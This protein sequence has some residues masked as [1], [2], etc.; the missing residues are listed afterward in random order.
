M[1]RS[2][3]AYDDMRVIPAYFAYVP[4]RS[5][6]HLDI[7]FLLIFQQVEPISKTYHHLFLF[8]RRHRVMSQRCHVSKHTALMHDQLCCMWAFLFLGL[9]VTLSLP[10]TALAQDQSAVG[11]FFVGMA[12]PVA[13]SRATLLL[14]SDLQ[15]PHTFQWQSSDVILGTIDTG[16]VTATRWTLI[17]GAPDRLVFVGSGNGTVVTGNVLFG[18]ANRAVVDIVKGAKRVR[19]LLSG[20]EVAVA[21]VDEHLHQPE[22]VPIPPAEVNAPFD[23]TPG[24][25]G[26]PGGFGGPP[27]GSGIPALADPFRIEHLQVSDTGDLTSAMLTLTL[28]SNVSSF[29][30]AYTLTETA[31]DSNL[32]VDADDAL[33]IQVIRY[34]AH[35]PGVIDTMHLFVVSMAFGARRTMAVYETGTD[36]EVFASEHL[37]LA[38]TMAQLPHPNESDMMTATLVSN[39]RSGVVSDTLAETGNDTLVF[40]SSDHAFRMTVDRITAKGA[41]AQD[42]L[43]AFVTSTQFGVSDV[44]INAIET[45]P[46]TLAFRTDALHNAGGPGMGPGAFN[47]LA[48][49]NKWAP[50]LLLKNDE[51]WPFV[52]DV[53]E[54]EVR[55]KRGEATSNPVQNPTLKWSKNVF[56]SVAEFRY[57]VL[58]QG[59]DTP[60]YF[61]LVEDHTGAQ[62]P[63]AL[64]GGNIDARVRPGDKLIASPKGMARP[65]DEILVVQ[66]D[67][68]QVPQFLFASAKYA[69]PLKFEIKGVETAFIHHITGT[70]KIGDDGPHFI[71]IGNRFVA[72]DGPEQNNGTSTV[73]T[74][75]VRASTYLP[76]HSMVPNLRTPDAR[77]TLQVTFSRTASDLLLFAQAESDR[78]DPEARPQVFVDPSILAL[79]IGPATQPNVVTVDM[80]EATQRA[81]HKPGKKSYQHWQHVSNIFP[82]NQ[83]VPHEDTSARLLSF[84]FDIDD[85]IITQTATQ[86]T[87]FTRLEDDVDVGAG[88]GREGYKNRIYGWRRGGYFYVSYGG[89]DISVLDPNERAMDLT[90]QS[91]NFDLNMFPTGMGRITNVLQQNGGFNTANAVP[92]AFAI[93]SA[94]AQG[95]PWALVF[96]TAEGIFDIIA[97]I[98]NN[99]IT[100]TADGSIY[101]V[102]TRSRANGER[103]TEG[104]FFPPFNHTANGSLG[105]L[106]L[107]LSFPGVST[108]VGDQWAAFVELESACSAVSRIPQPFLSIDVSNRVEFKVDNVDDFN[109]F[110]VIISE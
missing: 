88:S 89:K 3:S 107:P 59:E 72:N 34:A 86:I 77:F 24:E 93:A 25:P 52:Q 12:P 71:G 50:F 9:L 68:L 7:F 99:N 79:D 13:N 43:T 22:L 63:F 101:R 85:Q 33:A 69:T 66:V 30:Q 96:G 16:S 45:G 109:K 29:S 28:T 57:H 21:W 51:P 46:N 78:Q 4:Q 5:T 61:L 74:A 92:G 64:N 65:K 84:A 103:I 100:D 8:H 62:A 15:A 56:T 26:G 10:S 108:N 39:V 47:G 73:Y 110:K 27:A 6:R 42:D 102:L 49:G 55:R 83:G 91:G 58:V 94:I 98:D 70:I 82:H 31:P 40:E 53:V 37:E 32:F 41:V 67:I 76:F 23:H 19:Y 1:A 95:G 105:F 36:T 17:P 54:V 75:F 35:T 18:D 87:L 2:G 11:T 48:V 38:V 97:S 104:R 20:A 106:P 60:V 44:E 80:N 90:K 81:V 14:N